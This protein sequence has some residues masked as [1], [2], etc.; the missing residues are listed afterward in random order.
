[1]ADTTDVPPTKELGFISGL[2]PRVVGPGLHRWLAI[3]SLSMMYQM[4]LGGVYTVNSVLYNINEDLGPSPAYPWLLSA[5]TLTTGV[6]GVVM[7]QLGDVFGRRWVSMSTGISAII[8]AVIGIRA[9]SIDASTS[10]HPADSPGVRVKNRITNK[11]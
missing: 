5:A 3:F 4:A 1:M 10:N 2:L 11:T 9:Q 6:L 8:A 7:G